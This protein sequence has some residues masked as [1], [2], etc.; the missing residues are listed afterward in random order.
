MNPHAVH[1][2]TGNTQHFN[3]WRKENEMTAPHYTNF[4]DFSKVAE[5]AQQLSERHGKTV[6]LEDAAKYLADLMKPPSKLP[7]ALVQK[8]YAELANLTCSIIAAEEL[9]KS[10]DPT[11]SD[12]ENLFSHPD[13]DKLSRTLDALHSILIAHPVYLKIRDGAQ[14]IER[15]RNAERNQLAAQRRV[16]QKP[17]AV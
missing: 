11:F 2:R 4:T 17:Q 9:C 5:A 13:L 6:S 10:T 7:T 16:Q 12:V 15:K 1:L 8:L 14:S 3:P